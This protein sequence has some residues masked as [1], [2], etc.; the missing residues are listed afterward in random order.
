MA[1][2]INKQD[3]TTG[4]LIGIDYVHHEIHDGDSYM[5]HDVIA[6]LGDTVVQDYWFVTP[7]TTKW[8]HIGH[9][10]ESTGPL[11][12]EIFEGADRT[13]AKTKQTV[14]NRNRNST[15]ENTTF[16]YKN[17]ATG[18]GSGGTTDGTKIVWWKGGIANN[19][20]QN[21]TNVGTSNE[22][23]LKQ[24]RNYIFRI[25]SHMA[26]NLISV[27]FDFYEHTNLA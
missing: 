21:G 2:I 12:I 11:T 19:K 16:I 14:Y 23:I 27:S 22:K 4:A 8:A 26:A 20:V 7:N 1:I 18:T 9:S 3:T 5:Y 15:N 13:N 10:V 25:T 24:N 6:S 17:D